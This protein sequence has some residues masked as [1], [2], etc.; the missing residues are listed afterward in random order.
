MFASKEAEEEAKK[1]S[2]KT[3]IPGEIPSVQ[4]VSKEEQVPKTAA[5]TPEQIVAIKVLFA[6]IAPTNQLT[7]LKD[8][9][10]LFD[11]L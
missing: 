3:F 2:V 4:E 11:L 9:S 5:P 7:L 6:G 1:E 10:C 8:G